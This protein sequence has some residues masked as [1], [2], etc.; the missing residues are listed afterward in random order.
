MSPDAHS[1]FDAW[2]V[3]FWLLNVSTH[4]GINGYFGEHCGYNLHACVGVNHYDHECDY[5]SYEPRLNSLLGA[6]LPGSVKPISTTIDS[7]SM[8]KC[9]SFNRSNHKYY[10]GIGPYYSQ[11][12]RVE[13]DGT[14]LMPLRMTKRSDGTGIDNMPGIF[15]KQPQQEQVQVQQQPPSSMIHVHDGEGKQFRRAI[16]AARLAG[17]NIVGFYHVARDGSR[18]KEVIEEQ[19]RLLDSGSP[20]GTPPSLIASRRKDSASLLRWTD[21]LFL[22][23]AGRTIDDKVAVQQLVDESKLKYRHKITINFN[24]T[25]GRDE[26]QLATPQKQH[27]Y[28]ADQELSEGEYALMSTMQQ[29]CRT[30]EASGHKHLVYYFKAIGQCCYR[31]Q[32]QQAVSNPMASW[33]ESLTSTALAH[34]SICIR[35]LLNGYATCGMDY[36]NSLFP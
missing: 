34:P 5:T 12:V 36:A 22:N 16:M 35:A 31:K 21:Q 9:P 17:F 11:N 3:E 25:L 15:S 4:G 19:L 2:Q 6:E 8:E 18:W 23:V 27:E 7:T 28:D 14:V 1:R 24:R 20:S 30:Q 29:Y 33:R 10:R 26:Y 32:Q 13:E